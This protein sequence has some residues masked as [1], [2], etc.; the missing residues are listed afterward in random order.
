MQYYQGALWAQDYDGARWGNTELLDYDVNLGDPAE[1]VRD[2]VGSL[3][4]EA[5][6][7]QDCPET[8]SA[9]V[10][11][12]VPHT[13]DCDGLL[14][15]PHQEAQYLLVLVQPQMLRGYCQ[16]PPRPDGEVLEKVWGTGIQDGLLKDSD[17]TL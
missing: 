8:Q 4:Q 7:M 14:L 1:V 13:Q 3:R 16:V 11:V 5:A 9:P 17:G 2:S 12:C 10:D 15:A 6:V